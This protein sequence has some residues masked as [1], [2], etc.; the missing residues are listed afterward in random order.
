MKKNLLFFSLL[1]SV[2]FVNAQSSGYLKEGFEDQRFPPAGWT[3]VNLQ[4]PNI[5]VHSTTVAHEGTKSAFSSY[6][7]PDPKGVNYLITKKF[8]VAAG[9]SLTFWLTPLFTGYNDSLI[10][11]VSTTNPNLRNFVTIGTFADGVNYPDVGTWARESLSL[12][13]YAGQNVYVAFKH[14][15]ENGDGIYIDDVTLGTPPGKDIKAVSLDV[16]STLKTGATITPQATFQNIGSQTQTFDVTLL[17]GGYSSTKT[18]TGLAPLSTQQVTFDNFI[19]PSTYTSLDMVTYSSLAGDA[20]LTNDTIHK[21]VEVYPNFANNGWIISTDL[22]AG[23][24]GNAVTTYYAGTMPNDTAYLFSVGGSNN[25]VITDITAKFNVKTKKWSKV[26][27]MPTARYGGSAFTYNGKIYY[28]GGYTAAFV[29][30]D[31]VSVYDIATNT[32]S[33]GTALPV[34]IGDYAGCQYQ[35][36]L[37]YIIGGFD[38]VSDINTVY[39]YNANTD[40]WSTGTDFPG[41]ASDGNRAGVVNNTI[42]SV[43]GYSQD[44][45]TLLSQSYK[46]VINPSDP[47]NITWTQIANYPAGPTSRLGATGVKNSK[48]P[49]VYFTGGFDSANDAIGKSATWAYNVN[50]QDWEQGPDKP[51]GVSNISDFAPFIFHDTLYIASIGGYNGVEIVKANE[52]LQIG[53]VSEVLP[54]HMLNFTAALQNNKT[55]LNWKVSE[56]GAGGYYII[57]RSPDAVHYTDLSGKTNAGRVSTVISYTGYDVLPLKGYNYYRIEI[58]NGDGGI[59]YSEVRAV[60]NNSLSAA[61][62]AVNIYPNPTHGPL[63][64]VLQNNTGTDAVIGIAI[65]DVSGRKIVNENKTLGVSLNLTYRLKP[66][67]YVVN[68]LSQDGT[69]KQ[70][71]KVVVE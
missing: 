38:G 46:G 29:P 10:I 67:T 1:F 3:S 41:V 23:V 20:D 9:D 52:W 57:Q 30:T 39:I 31:E 48:S 64:I 36:S 65:S 4:G 12:S 16:P 58:V 27:S 33:T 32:W 68:M 44:E 71:Q 19:L 15:D 56:D 8:T 55:L 5:W 22:P 28:F 21:Q 24:F 34:A 18:I 70:S 26:A 62:Y 53:A 66:G 59:S 43:G 25:N 61:V 49:L 14:I 63:N 7:L 51:T 45:G 42:I 11:Q 47:G 69:W 13:A 54:I 60:N 35:D 40:S 2:A 37:I 17:G 50:A 6:S